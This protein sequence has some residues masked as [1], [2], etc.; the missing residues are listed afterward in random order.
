MG[1]GLLERYF[2]VLEGVL[3]DPCLDLFGLG[4]VA[5]HAI[6]AEVGGDALHLEEDAAVLLLGLDDLALGDRLYEGLALSEG[7]VVGG[8]RGVARER[9]HVF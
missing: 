2:I 1:R 5:E 4:V 8:M 9:P 7:A 3:G 6:L